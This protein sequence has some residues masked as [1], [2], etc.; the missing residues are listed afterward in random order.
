[1]AL[2]IQKFGGTSVADRACLLNVASIIKSQVEKGDQVIAVVSAQGNTTDELLEKI[3]EIT[4]DPDP[5]ERDA[6][7]ASG[8]Q[9]SAALLAITLNS[10]GVSARSLNAFQAD[11]QTTFDHGNAS[12]LSVNEER[13][14]N[15]LNQGET[16]VITGFQ[17][18]SDSE[19]TT[20]GRGGSDTSA[21]ALAVLLKADGCQ[22]YKDVDGVFDK[23]PRRSK[24]AV[25]YEKIDYDTM[26]KICDCGCGVLQKKCVELAKEHQIILA[27]LP[28]FNGGSGTL[29]SK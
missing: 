29:I 14:R 12:I 18:V 25:K 16:L 17:G 27:I 23:D 4:D 22:F 11:I 10:I 28:T 3:S 8:E 26:L 21:V 20:L 6:L 15:Y 13:I 24:D 1:M 2:I 7:I 5:R 19:I 9:I